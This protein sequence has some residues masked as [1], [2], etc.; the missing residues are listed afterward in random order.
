MYGKPNTERQDKAVISCGILLSLVL[1]IFFINNCKQYSP[2]YIIM[3]LYNLYLFWLIIEHFT[4][5]KVTSMVSFQT[6]DLVIQR[7]YSKTML[8]FLGLKI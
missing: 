4:C 8:L 7:E 2:P 6:Y 1:V 3:Q 5:T